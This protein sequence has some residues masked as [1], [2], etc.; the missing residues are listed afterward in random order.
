MHDR[1][2]CKTIR[3]RSEKPFINCNKAQ[4]EKAEPWVSRVARIKLLYYVEDNGSTFIWCTEPLAL[5]YK[6]EGFDIVLVSLQQLKLDHLMRRKFYHE[7]KGKL[8]LEPTKR[9]RLLE[10]KVKLQ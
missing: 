10:V 2:C 1:I 4:P 6:A 5:C 3:Q 9:L 7:I 8:S